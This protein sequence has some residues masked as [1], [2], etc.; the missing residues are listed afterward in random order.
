MLKK[1]TA[2]LLT[3]VLFSFAFYGCGGEKSSNDDNSP[4]E[5]ISQNENNVNDETETNTNTIKVTTE[6]ALKYE[7]LIS[8]DSNY[9]VVIGKNGKLNFDKPNA[10]PYLSPALEWENLV[11]VSSSCNLLVAV[12]STGNV[13]IVGASKTLENIDLSDFTNIVYVGVTPHCVYGLKSDGTVVSSGKYALDLSSWANVKQLSVADGDTAQV[14]VGLTNDAKVLTASTY[15]EILEAKN[16]TDIIQVS[17]GRLHV[18]GLKADGT[19]VTCGRPLFE[20][21]GDEGEFDVV[22]WE[23][24]VYVSADNQTT[25]GLKSDGTVVA[26][27]YNRS[28]YTKDW[29]DIVTVCQGDNSVAAL[30]IDGTLLKMGMD[31]FNIFN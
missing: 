28:S 1:V 26:T 6:D 22:A 17:A 14:V 29:T 12:D 31:E 27:G 30:K 8:K 11:Q 2:L 16:W 15:D 19:V 20:E 21:E 10:Y 25:V 9:S 3:L 4:D 7:K 5:T 23:D 18:A 13:H 24:I